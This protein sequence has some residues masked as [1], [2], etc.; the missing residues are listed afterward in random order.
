MA[1]AAGEV[2]EAS[3]GGEE[4]QEGVAGG[5]G[6]KVVAIKSGF[7]YVCVCITSA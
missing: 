4:R 1:R 5:E 7:D 3:V 2:D 6:G